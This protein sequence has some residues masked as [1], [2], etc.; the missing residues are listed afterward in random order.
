[1]REIRGSIERIDIPAK[2]ALDALAYTL[3]A[4]DAVLGEGR[5]EAFP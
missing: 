1:M 5:R 3:F 2:L 4:V